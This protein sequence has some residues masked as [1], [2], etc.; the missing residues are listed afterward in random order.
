MTPI[1]TALSFLIMTE[2]TELPENEAPLTEEVS[3]EGESLP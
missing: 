2:N 1:L 3:E